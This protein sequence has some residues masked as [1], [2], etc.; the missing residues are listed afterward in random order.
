M[1]KNQAGFATAYDIYI[2]YIH[3]IYTYNT[4]IVYACATGITNNNN[5]Q[6]CLYKS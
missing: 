2:E 4:Y 3:V 6:C 5:M 1:T